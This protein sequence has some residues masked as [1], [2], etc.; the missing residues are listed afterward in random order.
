MLFALSAAVVATS[1][2]IVMKGK[3][4][5]RGGILRG[6]RRTREKELNMPLDLAYRQF[7]SEIGDQP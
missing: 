1:A 7:Q 4:Q 6:E 5:S 2:G 3:R